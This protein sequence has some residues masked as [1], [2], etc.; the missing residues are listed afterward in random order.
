MQDGS[1][2]EEG[3]A[4][5]IDVI[6]RD[7]TPTKVS[8]WGWTPQAGA[9]NVGDWQERWFQTLHQAQQQGR[10]ITVW[11][12]PAQPSQALVDPSIRWRF[13]IFRLPFALVFTGV[14]LAAGWMLWRLLSGRD[15]TAPEDSPPNPLANSHWGLW[16]FTLFW[17]G[18]SFPMAALFWSDARAPWWVKA[19]LGIF[20]AIGAGMAW[21]AVQQTRK[22]WRYRG[23]VMTALPSRPRAGQPVEV[24]L[25]LPPRAAQHPA[26]DQF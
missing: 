14:G 11:V 21:A 22:V 6:I 2:Q 10:L 19:F 24:T 1:G 18:I 12:N 20:V 15:A 9:D 5:W 26:A 7:A 16:A 13:Q 4:F 8:V 3:I 25:V 23:L 17:C